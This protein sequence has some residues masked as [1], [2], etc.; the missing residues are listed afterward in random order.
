VLDLT[1]KTF[2]ITGANSGLGAATTRALAA[3]GGEVI[4]ACRDVDKASSGSSPR[5][6]PA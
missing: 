5:N 1:G 6:S 4:M 2:V 3:A